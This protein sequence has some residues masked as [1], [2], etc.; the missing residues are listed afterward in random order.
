[1]KLT[2]SL[3]HSLTTAR[4][5]LWVVAPSMLTCHW[6]LWVKCGI[7]ESKM[8]NQKCGMTLIGRG[9]KPR[10]RWLSADYHA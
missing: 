10:D 1:M 2:Y 5:R 7:A 3:T 4:N 8:W 6:R 9:H